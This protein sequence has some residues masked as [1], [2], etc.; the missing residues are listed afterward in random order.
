MQCHGDC[1]FNHINDMAGILCLCIRGLSVHQ[2]NQV[3]CKMSS[4][5]GSALA[6][7][8]KPLACTKSML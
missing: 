7:L 4:W 3:L 6:H 2:E 1:E 5:H 8:H